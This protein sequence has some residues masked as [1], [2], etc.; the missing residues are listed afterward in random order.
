VYGY[1]ESRKVVLSVSFLERSFSNNK[2]HNSSEFT[3]MYLLKQ[4]ILT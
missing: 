3:G 1:A 4:M 2:K